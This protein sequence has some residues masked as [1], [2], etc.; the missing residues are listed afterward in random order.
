MKYIIT[1]ILFF[2][3][4][5]SCSTTQNIKKNKLLDYKY[6][7]LGISKADSLLFIG[8]AKEAYM[9]YDN[10]FKT[11]DSQ[12]GFT[13]GEYYL[14]LKSKAQS[15]IKITKKDLELC[16]SK[17]GI[18]NKL[19]LSDSI[20]KKYYTNYKLE[21]DYKNLRKSY[22]AKMNLKLRNQIIKMT[23]RDQL[24][25]IY[26]E[27]SVK[28]KKIDSE[29]EKILKKLFIEDIYPDELIVGNYFI[30]DEFYGVQ[31]LLLHTSKD[32]RK[33]FFLPK[34]KKFI[35]QGKCTPY[36]YAILVDQM[37]LYEG[38][39]Q[40]YGTYSGTNLKKE[41]LTR[42]NK[43]RQKLDIGLP[44]VQYDIWKKERYN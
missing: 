11:Y 41:D 19:I 26:E 17:H 4:T 10:L 31:T 39:E 9:I 29:N 34:I 28:M 25:R 30:G 32:I 2:I 22:L 15:Q 40:V 16:F 18:T 13:T 38:K 3:F 1:S 24:Y 42:Y 12:N 43:N 7:F 23:E 33:L 20:L 8:K 14:Y 35:I 6:Y 27:D 5:F 36:T 21:E 37:H 44:S